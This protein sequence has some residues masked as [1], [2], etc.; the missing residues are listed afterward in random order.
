MQYY[1]V[2]W[3]IHGTLMAFAFLAMLVSMSVARYGKKSITGW[4]RKHKWINLVGA[5]GAAAAMII[6]G[7][8][9]S[10]SHGFHLVSTHAVL[11]LFTFLCIVIT[12]IVGFGILSRKVKPALKKKVRYIH[13]WLGRLTLVLMAVTIY[14]GLSISGLI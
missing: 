7:L 6:A 13:H 12:P 1:S 8:M 3:P 11:G 10:L 5:I 4:Y 14:Y 9:V 2:L